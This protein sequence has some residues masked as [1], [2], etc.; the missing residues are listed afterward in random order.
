MPIGIPFFIG[1]SQKKK[2]F[3]ANT[4]TPL[5]AHPK[6]ILK[7]IYSKMKLKNT[8]SSLVLII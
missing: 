4:N 1:I 6:S 2:V 8:L 5:Q 3:D 7:G